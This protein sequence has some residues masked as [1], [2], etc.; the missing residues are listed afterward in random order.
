MR[1]KCGENAEICVYCGCAALSLVLY[2]RAQP[3]SADWDL[4]TFI[5]ELHGGFLNG[6]SAFFRIE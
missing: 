1:R 4:H 5:V 3:L 6:V 2:S